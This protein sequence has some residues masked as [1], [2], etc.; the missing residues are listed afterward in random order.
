MYPFSKSYIEK[1]I[2]KEIDNDDYDE[3]ARNYNLDK[4]KNYGLFSIYKK[5][6]VTV[7]KKNIPF[8]F[9]LDKLK[10][11][12]W[13]KESERK[14]KEIEKKA[15]LG[16]DLSKETLVKLS[17]KKEDDK[18]YSNNT[19][20]KKEY[21]E[22]EYIEDQTPYNK[23][24]F[25]NIKNFINLLEISSNRNSY[26]DRLVILLPILTETYYLMDDDFEY[27]GDKLFVKK[28]LELKN[29]D[30][31]LYLEKEIGNF[32]IPNKEKIIEY[33]RYLKEINE[34]SDF[35]DVIKEIEEYN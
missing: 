18:K 23:L 15:I 27:K 34:T 6:G 28:V 22:N 10:Q 17:Y 26:G 25:I 11:F 20:M 12:P 5:W 3:I 19:Q 4:I 31:W 9:N 30:T 8:K 7:D 14:S 24:S 29:F 2:K 1:D 16:I 13:L 33:L 32:I 35:N 21:V